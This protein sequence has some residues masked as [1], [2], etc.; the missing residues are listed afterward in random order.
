MMRLCG[1]G[2]Q[3]NHEIGHVTSRDIIELKLAAAKGF[4]KDGDTKRA[5]ELRASARLVDHKDG[6][7]R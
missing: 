1:E 3:W 6:W 4:E 7:R 2:S 5:K